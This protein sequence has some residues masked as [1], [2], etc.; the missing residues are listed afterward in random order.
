MHALSAHLFKIKKKKKKFIR[1]YAGVPNYYYTYNM[2]R[3]PLGKF[4]ILLHSHMFGANSGLL[5][6]YIIHHSSTLFTQVV[7]LNWSFM[8]GQNWGY[9]Q[10][11]Q[12]YRVF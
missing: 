3:T 7:V 6:P 11:Q 10:Q 5:G 4:T 9:P 12:Q 1:A 8:S 2:N